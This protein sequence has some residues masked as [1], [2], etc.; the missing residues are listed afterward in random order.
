MIGKRCYTITKIR[1]FHHEDMP[2]FDNA[3]LDKI[4]YFKKT[5]D[6][7]DDLSYIKMVKGGMYGPE[8]QDVQYKDYDSLFTLNERD[9]FLF[10]VQPSIWKTKDLLKIYKITL[11]KHIREFETN[12]T[13]ICRYMNIKGLY[14]FGGEDKRGMFHWDS[15]AYPYICTAINKGKWNTSEYGKELLELFSTY[16]IDPSIRGEI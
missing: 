12:A 9:N 16:S 14:Y 6:K 8:H 4:E 13:E 2:L 10:A 7:E 11:I 1:I 3:D 15:D 5:L